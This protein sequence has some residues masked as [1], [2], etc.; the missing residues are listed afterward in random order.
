MNGYT[1]LTSQVQ[2]LSGIMDL[3]DKMDVT[4][5][6]RKRHSQKKNRLRGYFSMFQL[7]FNTHACKSCV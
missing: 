2:D 3:Q 6:E 1:E 4:C 7:N 5:P